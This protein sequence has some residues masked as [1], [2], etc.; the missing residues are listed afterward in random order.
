MKNGGEGRGNLQRSLRS[1]E[2]NLYKNTSVDVSRHE[3]GLVSP[4]CAYR[5]IFI[6]CSFWNLSLY[7]ICAILRNICESLSAHILRSAIFIARPLGTPS[8]KF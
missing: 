1:S 8:C 2:L 5:V 6:Y 4:C 3:N 7:Y